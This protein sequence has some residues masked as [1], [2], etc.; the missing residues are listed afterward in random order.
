MSVHAHTR[1]HAYMHAGRS[2]S[3][4]GVGALH[5]LQEIDVV[6]QAAQTGG[7]GDE[8]RWDSM[9]FADVTPEGEFR[10]SPR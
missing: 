9:S 7:L 5:A 8:G 3:I 1:T 6:I 4:G 10:Y 2:I